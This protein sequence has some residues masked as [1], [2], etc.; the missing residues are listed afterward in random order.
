MGA[1]FRADSRA[2]LTGTRGGTVRLW[3]LYTGQPLS[4]PANRPGTLTAMALR[5]DGSAFAAGYSDGMT[6]LWDLATARPVGPPLVHRGPV[7]AV[8]FTPGGRTLLSID[9]F[10]AV[11]TWAVP[12]PATDPVSRL[13]LRVQALTGMELQPDQAVTP[14]D[15]EAWRQR[16]RQLPEPLGQALMTGDEAEALRQDEARARAAE[17]SAAPFAALWHLDR[18]IASRPDDVALR[19]RRAIVQAATG[20]REAAEQDL[21]RALK[22][23]PRDR[24]VDLLALQADAAMACERWELALWALQHAIAARPADWRLYVDR[25]E[26]L[27]HLSRKSERDQDRVRA[28][29][30]GADSLYLARTAREAERAGE[31]ARAEALRDRA[32]ERL[33]ARPSVHLLLELAADQVRRNRLEKAG[34]LLDRILKCPEATRPDH[35]DVGLLWL[36]LGVPRLYRAACAKLL[37][38]SGDAPS[39]RTA[40]ALAW[41]C[42]LGPHAVA[43]PG[44]VVRLAEEALAGASTEQRPQ[45]LTTLGAALYRAGRHARAVARLEEAI[46][47]GNEQGLPQD[48]AFLAMAQQALGDSKAARR[49]LGKLTDRLPPTFW[50][51]L[52]L[53]LLQSEAEALIQANGPATSL[54]APSAR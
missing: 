25:A 43:D 8:A 9:N 35:L 39:P 54:T 27:D 51:T 45:A 36:H 4:P 19:V 49:W 37:A 26:A 38:S 52:E 5:P 50:E 18:L 29:E 1:V 21:A 46:R 41:Q 20:K 12:S 32:I 23:G 6:R 48:W 17:V 30:H 44:T 28:I 40:H 3:D 15:A 10:A 16:L 34:D 14:L 47:L 7:L 11:R 31:R 53:K 42:V 24:C 13:K 22:V 2:V 33:E